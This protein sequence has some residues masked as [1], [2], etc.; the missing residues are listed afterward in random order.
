M[1]GL[2]RTIECTCYGYLSPESR[3]SPTFKLHDGFSQFYTD[4][5]ALE[6]SLSLEAKNGIVV[7]KYKVER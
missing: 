6:G 2:V 5:F 4:S 7:A 1:A 3:L